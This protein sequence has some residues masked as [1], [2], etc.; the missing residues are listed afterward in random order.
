MRRF[1]GGKMERRGETRHE[2]V[3]EA[4]FVNFIRD[5]FLPFLDASYTKRAITGAAAGRR[6]VT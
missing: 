5:R 3:R 6:P 2:R 4:G 1:T